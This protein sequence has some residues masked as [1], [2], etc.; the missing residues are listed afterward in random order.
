MTEVEPFV[1]TSKQLE[2]EM[3]MLFNYELG[4]SQVI[5][6]IIEAK[7]PLVGHNMFLDMLFIYSQ[8]IGNLPNTMTDFNN[9][10]LEKFPVVYDTKCIAN[11]L[12]LFQKTDLKYMA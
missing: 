11:S 1:E 9:S 5:Q 4:F 6:S 10:W 3:E 7:K 8:F 2:I 12:G